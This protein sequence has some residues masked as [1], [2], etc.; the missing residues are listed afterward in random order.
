[1]SSGKREKSDKYPGVYWREVKR[2]D[3]CGTERMYYILYRK[4]GKGSKLIEEPIGRASR[5]MTEALANRERAL[6]LAGKLSNKEKRQAD[7]RESVLGNKA[8]DIQFLWEVYHKAH[9]ENRSI[10]D[11]YNRYARHVG[12]NIGKIKIADLQTEHIG[13]L[14]K[15]LE[16][17]GLSAQSVKHCLALV[18]RIIRYG[19]KSNLL[20][21]MP[22][23]NFEM[24][25]V[26]NL[27]TENMTQEELAAYLKAL[28]EETDQ[29]LA[30]LFRLALVT[31]IRKSALLALRW[32]DCD[33]EKRLI[34]LDAQSAKNKK[35]SYIPM[36]DMALFILKQ[37]ERQGEYVFPGVKGHRKTVD[38]MARRIR[39]KAG[40]PKS[41][42]PVHGLRHVFASHMASSGQVD[43]NILRTLLTHGSLAMTQRYTHLADDALRR[44]ANV[45]NSLIENSQEDKE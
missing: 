30:A 19:A 35:T 10:Q 6:R 22:A 11:D 34:R 24:P 32:E 18:K 17:Y 26:D 28:D 13:K 31:G 27:V 29:N 45:A 16:A 37:I 14:R 41:F 39:D 12:P 21:N 43:I 33:F 5:G 15:K 1:M 44:A 42:R 7:K 4:G 25:K 2:L 9:M 23:I 38:D 8:L 36:N 40:L 3:G 20:P